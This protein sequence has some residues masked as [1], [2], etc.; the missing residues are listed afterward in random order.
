MASSQSFHT[1][2]S[3]HPSIHPCIRPCL[4]RLNSQKEPLRKLFRE[5]RFDKHRLAIAG[6][7]ITVGDVNNG[8][9]LTS[10]CIKQAVAQVGGVNDCNGGE[11]ELDPCVFSGCA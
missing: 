7:I 5:I 3:I 4:S 9:Y 2:P 1:K 8:V 6:D 11:L 10:T